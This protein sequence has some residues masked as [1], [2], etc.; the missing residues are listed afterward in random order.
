MEER[1]SLR[2]QEIL[3]GA[4]CG[5]QVTAGIRDHLVEFLEPY[6]ARYDGMTQKI[7]LPLPEPLPR[8]EPSPWLPLDDDCVT[9]KPHE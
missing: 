2:L 9:V 8:P 6:I 3:G 1:C 5:P 7:H 4:V